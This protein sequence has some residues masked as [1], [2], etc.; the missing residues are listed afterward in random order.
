[1]W[2]QP[3]T[4]HMWRQSPPPRCPGPSE[5]AGE[6][7][8]AERRSERLRGQQGCGG[9]GPAH[10]ES[11][12]LLGWQVLAKQQHLATKENAADKIQAWW[13]GTLVRRTLLVAAL[14]A[15]VIQVWWRA[16]LLRQAQKL[17]Q[18]L[19]KV[20][21]V[22]EQAAVR[23]QSCI[24]MCQCHQRYCQV[25][26]TLCLLQKPRSSLPTQVRD[27]P[28]EQPAGPVKGLEFHVEILSV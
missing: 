9:W 16:L 25:R 24:R 17:Q 23:L 21:V 20:Y 5:P 6:G 15:W 26:N 19:L 10:W 28:Q 11:S 22:Q 13:R 3:Q 2:S 1:M 4:K 12:A 7:P 8:V 18:M 27:W 14:R